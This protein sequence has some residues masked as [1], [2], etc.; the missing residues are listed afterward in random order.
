MAKIGGYANLLTFQQE[1]VSPPWWLHPA[2]QANTVKKLFP[3]N[4]K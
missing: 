3:D 4:G 1:A 2:Y